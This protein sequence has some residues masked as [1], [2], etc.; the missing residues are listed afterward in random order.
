MIHTWVYR[1]SQKTHEG[2]YEIH[3]SLLE[4]RYAYKSKQEINIISTKAH[5][6][7][8]ITQMMLI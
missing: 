6:R 2:A 4:L 7:S 8:T 5:M 1:C 3:K